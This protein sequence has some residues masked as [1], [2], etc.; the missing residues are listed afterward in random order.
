MF[1]CMKLLE[2]TGICV[3]PGSGF[4]QREGTFHFRWV[5]GGTG[6]GSGLEVGG[7]QVEEGLGS[8]HGAGSPPRDPCPHLGGGRGGGCKVWGGY[9]EKGA[10]WVP[11]GL[12]AGW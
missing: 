11:N 8:H 2:E 10:T 12:G 5:L 7:S 9:G 1:F 6:M 3:V 4:G